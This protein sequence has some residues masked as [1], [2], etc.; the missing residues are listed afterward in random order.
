MVEN[1]KTVDLLIIGGGINGAGIAADAAGRGLTVLLCEKSDLG[2]ATSS[3][4]TK[5]IHGGLRYLEHYEFR[6]V[7]ES[8]AER[9]VLLNAAPH[10]VWPMRFRLPHHPG[11]RPAWMIRA[12][13]FLYD[14][15]GRRVSLPSSKSIHFSER[16]PLLP[17][18]QYGFEYSDCWVDDA[19]LVV[20]N[21]MQART[22]GASV[23]TRT[24]CTGLQTVTLEDGKPGWRV[25]L[26]DVNNLLETDVNARCV[27]NAA[28]PWVGKLGS[29]LMPD[30]P[31]DSVRLVKG[32]HIVVPR[33]YDGDESYL[34]QHDDGRVIFVIPYEEKYALIGTTEQDYRGDP[35]AAEIS[36]EEV[37][38]LLR[39]VNQ[40]F[41]GVLK[42][43]DVVHHFSGV[44]PLLA[45]ASK[46]ASKVSRDYM[47]ELKTE[48]A[49][50]LSVFGGKITTYRKLAEAAVNKLQAVF[51][52]LAPDWTAGAELP[53]GDFSSQ[54]E[55]FLSLKQHYP[56]LDPMLISHW[57]RRYGTLTHQ[58]LGKAVDES[59]LGELIGPGLYAIEVDYLLT[60]EWA[61]TADD[62]LWR[63]TK[64]GLGFEE[65]D[66]V[67]L[68]EY[69]Q[70][71]AISTQDVTIDV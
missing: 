25:S 26:S 47:L 70:N 24:A 4:S 15:L 35:A 62:I 29:T 36:A 22:A 44:R 9:E 66:R 33:I 65:A 53:G 3:A 17:V 20:L 56:G 5:L 8:L 38:Y 61:Q 12:G 16:G 2:G 30:N 57:V 63:R 32:S 31:P 13:L 54:A 37:A 55:L 41:R 52:D 14:H 68:A 6:L 50:M 21:A 60:N 64:L 18:Y 48:P 59:E 23:R 19:R 7:R 40:Y 34:L 58:L 45:D 1:I 43:E 71:H 51:P 28:G 39:I 11:L 46:N 49:P 67:R 27:I 10:I 42:E 69:L